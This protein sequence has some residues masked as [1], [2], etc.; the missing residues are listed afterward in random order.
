MKIIEEYWNMSMN[1]KSRIKMKFITTTAQLLHAWHFFRTKN[2]YLWFKHNEKKTYTKRFLKAK[3]D[4]MVESLVGRKKSV[5]LDNCQ[6]H[7]DATLYW[8][9]FS[10]TCIEWKT[11]FQNTI[12]TGRDKKN[13]VPLVSDFYCART[14]KNDI[15]NFRFIQLTVLYR[16]NLMLGR[17]VTT[18]VF[19]SA[20]P[21]DKG[22]IIKRQETI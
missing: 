22:L 4:G 18:N 14:A 16:S 5:F 19:N 8:C 15:I 1:A 21:F 7:Y 17:C 2:K 11:H 13:V 9:M 20:V 12:S 3:P 6:N 10:C